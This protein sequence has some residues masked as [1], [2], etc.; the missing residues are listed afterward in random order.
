MVFP[1]KKFNNPEE[2]SCLGFNLTDLDVKV[3][4]GY[5]QVNSNY[6]KV[7]KPNN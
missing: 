4:Q 7:E 1:L 2:F 3:N 6:I 5:V